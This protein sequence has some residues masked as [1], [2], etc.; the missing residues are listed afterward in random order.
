MF[1]PIAKFTSLHASSGIGTVMEPEIHRS[2]LLSVDKNEML[3]SHAVSRFTA[4]IKIKMAVLMSLLKKTK[5]LCEGRDQVQ[6]ILCDKI[7]RVPFKYSCKSF[8]LLVKI[9]LH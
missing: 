1:P 4:S 5:G 6:T 2:L 8:V 9:A 7:I 3:E